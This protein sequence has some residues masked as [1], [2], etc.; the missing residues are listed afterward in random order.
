MG[1]NIFGVLAELNSG[2]L[3]HQPV[4]HPRQP[5]QVREMQS[6]RFSSEKDD[7]DDDATDTRSTTGSIFPNS[8]P[9]TPAKPNQEPVYSA[10]ASDVPGN[11]KKLNLQTQL[12]FK[13]KRA[14]CDFSVYYYLHFKLTVDMVAESYDQ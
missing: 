2:Q 3:Y 9:S 13:D 4:S 7:L 1:A 5:S 12:G 14:Y 6:S 8:R 11:T 10:D